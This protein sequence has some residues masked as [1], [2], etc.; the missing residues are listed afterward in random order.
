MRLEKSF[1]LW[2]ILRG[3]RQRAKGVGQIEETRTLKL[4]TSRS[5]S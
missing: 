1:Q 4:K 2:Y 3:L 5:Q